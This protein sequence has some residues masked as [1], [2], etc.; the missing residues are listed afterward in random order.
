MKIEMLFS[1]FILCNLISTFINE[2]FF[3]VEAVFFFIVMEIEAEQ[4]E[5]LDKP[6]LLS[7]LAT[8]L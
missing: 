8:F 3:L 1:K 2:S 5:F 6:F 7:L 4:S